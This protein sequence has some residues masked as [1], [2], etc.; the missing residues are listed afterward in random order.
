MCGAA[1][2]TLMVLNPRDWVDGSGV[3]GRP[4]SVPTF[5]GMPLPYEEDIGGPMTAT[6]AIM[7]DKMDHAQDSVYYANIKAF[8]AKRHAKQQKAWTEAA[9][10]SDAE[11][12]KCACEPPPLVVLQSN[13]PRCPK[14]R[15]VL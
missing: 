10:K 9:L 6:E 3:H 12:G 5:H 14:C 11:Q 2:G 15:R 13:P 1:G 4:Y 7:L 8:L